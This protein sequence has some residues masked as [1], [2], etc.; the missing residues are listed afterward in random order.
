MS[1]R[2]SVD[3]GERSYDILVGA[4]LAAQ[5]GKW[6]KPLVRGPLPVVTDAKCR[7]AASG[8]PAGGVETSRARGKAHRAGAGRSTKSFRGLE[9]LCTQLLATG[10]AAAG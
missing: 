7:E 10:V 5:A 8:G 1:E 3:L 2:I 4:G 9:N 6:L